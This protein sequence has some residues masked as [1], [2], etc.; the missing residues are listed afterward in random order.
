[1]AKE[2]VMV[3][4]EAKRRKVT[5]HASTEV[6]AEYVVREGYRYVNPYVFG[7]QTH[8]K[9]RW[10]GRTLLEIFTAEFGSFSPEYYALA[11]ESGRI[12]LNGNLVPP[13]TVVKNG[14][15]LCH[16]THRHE[17][18][19]SG[20]DIQI[21]HETVDLPAGVPT[22]PCGAYRFNSL[23]Y[24]LMHMRPDI[25][26]LHIV[27]R[28]DR[29]TSGV[30]ILAKNP[31]TA[32]TLSTCIADRTA[33]KTYLAR[34]RGAFPVVLTSSWLEQL[35]LPTTR[36]SVTIDGQWLRIQCPLVCKSHKDG[37]WSWALPTDAND[38]SLKEAETLVQFYSTPPRR[39]ADSDDGTTVVLVKPV[40]GRTHQ[41]RLHLQL[42]G[43]PIA[44]DPCYGGTLH[45]GKSV[46]PSDNQNGVSTWREQAKDVVETTIASKLPREEGETEDAF[47]QRTCQWCARSVPNENHLHCA[48]IWLHAWRYE[49]LGET[50]QVA[51]PDWVPPVHEEGAQASATVP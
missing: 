15:L 48:R 32:R 20:D 17:P 21:A 4:R 41:I 49:L 37:V 19:V 33:S 25:P 39:D 23:H 16:K 12:T 28:L 47:L 34:V 26:K 42:L 35:H 18:P 22:H 51:A 9:Q 11:I 40:T 29:L 3:S 7:F 14:D 1:M 13:T 2:E 50:F 46:G 36:A 38:P 24:I 44:N 31:S 43:L 45:F 8:A 6:T 5:P 30:V 10:F 27:H